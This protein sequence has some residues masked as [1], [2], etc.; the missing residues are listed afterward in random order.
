MMRPK[1]K[2]QSQPAPEPLQDSEGN[3]PP[4]SLTAVSQVVDD[5]ALTAQEI[6]Q[7]K[8]QAT[9][10]G[11]HREQMLRVAADFENFKKRAA[12]ERQELSKYAN[13]SLLQKF[14]PVLD[15]F[16]MA[17]Q[18]ANGAPGNAVQQ[19]QAGV[20]MIHQQLRN[21]L[22]EAGLEEI[23]AN[24]KEFDPNWHEAISQQESA[25]VSEGKVLQQLRKGYKLRDRL[26]R[27]AGVIVAKKPAA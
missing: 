19:L 11:E 10:A 26:L 18:A 12:R 8:E 17:L 25:E 4:E 9:K 3:T 27:P 22:A 7:L 5:P 6:A 2:E 20:N 21:V 15:N 13:E 16:D 24:G 1:N 23:D 14:I